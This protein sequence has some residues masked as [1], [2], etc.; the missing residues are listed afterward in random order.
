MYKYMYI[1][2][3]LLN[4]YM[5]TFMSVDMYEQIEGL[6]NAPMIL[7]ISNPRGPKY[8]RHGVCWV[9]VSGTDFWFWVGTFC[10]GTWS[11]RIR[12]SIATLYK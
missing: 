11:L 9:S 12:N 2:I 5:Y 8:P 3:C 4:V 1:Y 7:A 10:S 6:A